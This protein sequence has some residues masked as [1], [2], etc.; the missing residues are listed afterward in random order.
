M[1][2]ERARPPAGKSPVTTADAPVDAETI[3][4]TIITALSAGSRR[5]DIANLRRFEALLRSHIGLLIGPAREAADR[6]W[7]GKTEWPLQISRL[8]AIDQQLSESVAPHDQFAHLAQVQIL[9]RDCQ[10][11]FALCQAAER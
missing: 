2:T 7:H 6:L 4:D 1:D 9:A 10:W 3:R 11:L 8:D 5:I